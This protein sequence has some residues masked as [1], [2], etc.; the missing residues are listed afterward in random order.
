MRAIDDLR[1]R[2]DA[3]RWQR[4]TEVDPEDELG[5]R[6]GVVTAIAIAFFTLVL[7][8]IVVGLVVAR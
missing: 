2:R 4:W 6:S 7:A 3:R 5:R 8:I 1:R